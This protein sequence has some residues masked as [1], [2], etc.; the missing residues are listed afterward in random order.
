MC[1]DCDT[2]TAAL[3]MGLDV[4]EQSNHWEHLFSHH[5]QREPLSICPKEALLQKHA[6]SEVHG[7]KKTTC[8]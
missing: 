1:S 2:G 3:P 4:K 5:L 8:L 7:Q 6:V